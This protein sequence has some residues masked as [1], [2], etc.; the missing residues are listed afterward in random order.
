[1]YFDWE[2]KKWKIF[3]TKIFISHIKSKKKIQIT[4][5]TSLILISFKKISD[6]CLLSL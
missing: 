6:S 2:K 1:M 5:K 3:G 4:R